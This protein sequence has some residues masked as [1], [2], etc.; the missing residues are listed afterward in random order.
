ME[1]TQRLG[2]ILASVIRDYKVPNVLEHMCWGQGLFQTLIV[3]ESTAGTTAPPIEAFCVSL[4]Q[5]SAAQPGP[6]HPHTG[7]RKGDGQFGERVPTWRSWGIS[8]DRSI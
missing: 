6:T 8:L 7:V 4:R 2:T 3:D 5:E 1:R